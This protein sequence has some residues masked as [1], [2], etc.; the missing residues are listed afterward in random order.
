MNYFSYEG[1][2]LFNSPNFYQLMLLNGVGCDEK[3]H[4]RSLE[5]VLLPHQ[6]FQI[7]NMRS[8]FIAEIKTDCYQFGTQ[9]FT[10]IRFATQEV[11][12]KPVLA[13]KHQIIQILKKQV[14]KRYLWGGTVP[15]PLFLMLKF[16]PPKRN[17]TTF[18]KKQWV[19]DGID[20]SGILHY[21]TSG[22]T[23]RNTSQLMDYGNQVSEDEL[24]PLDLILIHKHVLI[25]VDDKTIVHS[26]EIKGVFLEN[27]QA[28]LAQLK[29]R[30]IDYQCRRFS[31]L[32]VFD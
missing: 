31:H 26:R 20:C 22:F 5:T 8:D 28:K 4:F 24:K 2:P 12:K 1:A 17:L 25:V 10:D 27:L 32:L 23:P 6:S 21:A 11:I 14:G 29:K 3:G 9:L 18:E 16:Y 30:K 7:V 19:L 15:H 13:S